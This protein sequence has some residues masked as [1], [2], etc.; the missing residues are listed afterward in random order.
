[1]SEMNHAATQ[2]NGV[3]PNPMEMASG[4][5]TPAPSV[6]DKTNGGN[7]TTQIIGWTILGL[8]SASI[9]LS[10]FYYAKAIRQMNKEDKELKVEIESVKSELQALKSSQSAKKRSRF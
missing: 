4:G 9:I 8:S 2:M 3:T 10:V 7:R 5:T 1:M 6:P